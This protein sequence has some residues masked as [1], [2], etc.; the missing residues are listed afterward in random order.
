MRE[1]DLPMLPLWV[2]DHYMATR[3]LASA[4]RGAYFDL[5]CCQWTDGPL[6]DD[7]EQLS[8]LCGM[9]LSEFDRCWSRLQSLF[10]KT[11]QGWIIQ[12]VEDE[13]LRAVRTIDAK[14]RGAEATN[15]KRYGK[16]ALSD[17]HSEDSATRS[18]TGERH[19]KRHA[20][21]SLS[22]GISDSYS[23]SKTPLPPDELG[24]V[25]LNSGAEKRGSRANGTNPRAVEGQRATSD[26]RAAELA[27]CA[28]LREVMG[29]ADFREPNDFE[30]VRIYETSLKAEAKRRG[31][32]PNGAGRFGEPTAET[33]AE[34]E[35]LRASL[36]E[37]RAAKPAVAEPEAKA[38]ATASGEDRL[39]Q[40]L[41]AK[42]AL[43][44]DQMASMFRLDKA[45]VKRIKAEEEAAHAET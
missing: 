13:Y 5:M 44:I 25:L 16:R 40:V 8:R 4:E 3:R 33:V 20:E 45:T 30:S 6:P 22:A 35:R 26:A 38:A 29:L 39:R 21:A 24:A 32:L 42:V 18:A 15:A 31:V 7:H 12:S 36:A 34:A 41:R 14:A 17:T 1:R 2:R 23:V 11:E 9:T 43:S 28:R 10:K 27:E 19:A 37:A